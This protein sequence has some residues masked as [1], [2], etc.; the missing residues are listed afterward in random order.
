MAKKRRG[1]NKQNQQL[2][3]GELVTKLRE[4]GETEAT[5]RHTLRLDP[6]VVRR[7]CLAGTPEPDK[8][9]VTTTSVLSV[10]E[11]WVREHVLGEEEETADGGEQVIGFDVEWRPV[12]RKGEKPTVA[13]VQ[14]A[15]SAACL[16]FQILWLDVGDKV[17][18]NSLLAAVLRDTSRLKV[19]V[20]VRD[21]S[22]KLAE[23]WGIEVLGRT[24]LVDY[25]NEL[26]ALEGTAFAGR[27]PGLR[28][29]AEIFLDGLELSKPKKITMSDWSQ[30]C[31]SDRQSMYAALDAFVSRAIYVA[32]EDGSWASG[33][34][35]LSVKRGPAMK[36]VD[37]RP[38]RVAAEEIKEQREERIRAK[39][40][41][42]RP[43]SEGEG[44]DGSSDKRR[45]PEHE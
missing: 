33:R 22:I 19:G 24:E 17:L 44:K 41:G 12:R 18:R 10:A 25:A 3:I 20:G 11:R 42:K 6:D 32:L 8:V 13:V 31:L 38:A 35:P 43:S 45:K 16:V 4:A 21:D 23:S 9:T 15:T 34:D 1:S 40:S 14:L 37:T 5:P 29:L 36:S 39:K 28:S 27:S 2:H 26:K 30:Q 7:C